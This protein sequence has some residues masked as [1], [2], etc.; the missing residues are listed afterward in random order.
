MRATL[1][2][3]ALH[4][5]MFPTQRWL[6]LA[7]AVMIALAAAIEFVGGSGNPLMLL[8]AVLV[9]MPL[10][11]TLGIVFRMLSLP[12]THR[13]LPFFRRRMLAA[14]GL[15]LVAA[16]AA[17]VWLVWRLEEPAATASIPYAAVAWSTLLWLPLFGSRGLATLVLIVLAAWIAQ[18]AVEPRLDDVAAL[19]VGTG[20]GA[21]WIAFA[22]WYL[23]ARPLDALARRPSV[24]PL[25]AL[26]AASDF[27][28][29]RAVSA[30]KSMH[31]YL[32]GPH[33]LCGP[34]A[35]AMRYAI[36]L[37]SVGVFYLVLGA[38]EFASAVRTTFATPFM[39]AALSFPVALASA[40][41]ARRLWLRAPLGRIGLFRIVERSLARSEPA[42]LTVLA[43]AIVVL[44]GTLAGVA[45][46]HVLAI[47][48]A[49]STT[50]VAGTC[51]GLLIPLRTR[52]VDWAVGIAYAMIALAAAA[53]A[54][55]V[56]T[57]I[58]LGVACVQAAGA[59]L[60][61]F[62]AQRRWHHID[63]LVVRAGRIER[64]T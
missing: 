55:V 9:L 17:T 46:G 58:L 22:A 61:R 32:H 62:A 54:A 47:V 28:L 24:R 44:H 23:R 51:I 25:E 34:G 26:P 50:A 37:C 14:T 19:A 31:A 30:S 52:P 4:F 38:I 12:R 45:L 56:R 3:A 15:V 16:S 2:L 20:L 41:R 10:A 13:L 49:V 64:S 7:G 1:R 48:L 63:W 18:G 36:E 39:V 53:A 35:K 57:D 11:A 21:A 59:A 6:T 60:C 43:S 40:A 27:R 8:G 33:A 5:T 42:R 29:A